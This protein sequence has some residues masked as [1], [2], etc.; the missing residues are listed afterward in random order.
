[1]SIAGLWIIL[2]K[3]NKPKKFFHFCPVSWGPIICT[4]SSKI[5]L[6][7]KFVCIAISLL[8]NKWA[9]HHWWIGQSILV[10]QTL[11]SVLV[12]L[13]FLWMEYHVMLFH[14]PFAKQG[15][16]VFALLVFA[17]H[18][19]HESYHLL[20]QKLHCH[21]FLQNPEQYCLRWRRILRLLYQVTGNKVMTNWSVD[22]FYCLLI[23]SQLKPRMIIKLRSK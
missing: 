2:I 14:G 13:N 12:H 20:H 18:G 16:L 21:C 11:L 19:S 1:M 17:L 22:C 5:A 9:S 7:Y 3:K 15:E 4:G 6:S 8:Q 23:F 10:V